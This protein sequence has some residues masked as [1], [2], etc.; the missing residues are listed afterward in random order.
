MA[1]KTKPKEA[2]P[3]LEVRRTPLSELK[4]HPRNYRQHPADQIQHLARS[5]EEHGCYRNVVCAKDGTILAGHGV[6]LALQYLGRTEVDCAWLNVEPES[7][8]ALKVLTGDNEIEHLAEQDDRLLS[9]LL[10]EIKQEAEAGLL[11]TGYD[12]A[13][14]A[15]LV[16]VTR[17]AS[18]VA[19]FNAAAHWAGMPDY[20]P[21]N[22]VIKVVVNFECEADRQ[23]F[24]K[25]LGISIGGANS[26]WWPPKEKGEISEPSAVVFQ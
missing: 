3:M 12:E 8:A 5:I 15:N 2:A 22:E 25:R 18:E 19:D 7:P 11:G 14:L 16:M 6:T 21:G 24:S 4:P 23:D 20:D 1:A 9:E 26:M 17:P 10:R 13:M